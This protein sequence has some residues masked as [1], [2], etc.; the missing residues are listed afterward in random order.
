M[1]LLEHPSAAPPQPGAFAAA[2]APATRPSSGSAT[3]CTSRA[4]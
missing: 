1:T 2:L 3:R 4:S